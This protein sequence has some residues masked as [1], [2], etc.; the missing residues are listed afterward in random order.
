ME[1]TVEEQR[2]REAR[3][4]VPWRQWG[5]YLAERQWGTVREDYSDDGNAWDYFTHDQSRSRAYRWGEDGIAAV[6]DDHSQL[7]LAL[8]LW[9]GADPILKERLFGLTNSEGNHGE[10]VKELYFYVDSTPTHSW[11]RYRYRYPQR[12]FPY[13]DL[14]RTNA[15]RGYDDDEYELLDTGV[16]D[17]GRYFDVDVDYAKDGPQA[18]V[19]RVTV[20]NRGPEA[21]PVDVLPTLWFRNTWQW[22]AEH[23]KP[24]L[25]R[26]EAAGGVHVRATHHRLGERWLHVPAG[27]QLLFCEN[28]TNSERLWGT[29][30]AAAYVKDGIDRAVVHGEADAVGGERGTKVAVR[31]TAVVPAGGE[32]SFVVRLD[33]VAPSESA[34]VGADVVLA[35]RQ[36]EADEFYASITPP[37]LDADR[38][39]VLRTALAGMLWSKQHYFFDLDRWLQE[40][41]GHPLR[42]PRRQG[43]RNAG[44]AHMYNDDV[45]SMPDTWEYPWYAA[46]DLAFHTMA[47]AMV[48]PDFA[49]G[50]LELMLSS[51]YLHPTGQIPAY[52]WN[53]SDVNPPVHAWA[54]ALTY[55]LGRMLA[56]EPGE[57]AAGAD[58]VGFLEDAFSRLLVNFTWWVNRKD[59]SGNN[60]FEGGFLG[61][62]NVGVFDRSKPL[63]TGGHLEQADGTAWMAFYSQSMI[64]LAVLLSDHEPAYEGFIVKFVQHWMQIAM[65]M[66]PMGDH[67]D[68]MWDEEDGFFYDVLRLPDGTGRRLEVRSMVGLLPLCATAVV[69][70]H[71]VERFPRV[72]A[73]LRY[74]VERNADLLTGIPDPRVPGVDGRRLLA[75]VDETKLRR[76]LARM[77][78]EERFLSPHGIRSVSKWHEEH[79]YVFEADGQRYEVRYDPAD[80][81]SGAFGGN[82]NWRGPVWMPVNV[83]LIRALLQFYLYY[84]DDFTVE[85]PTGSGV[86]KTLYE[87]AHDLSDRL[88][89]TFTPGPDGRRPVFG[90]DTRF[91]DDPL[92]QDDLLFFEYFDGDTGAGL[93]ASHQTGWTGVVARLAQMFASTDAATVLHGPSRP[94]TVPYRRIADQSLAHRDDL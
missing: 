79:P 90:D 62:D 5:P 35:A 53:F 72:A 21:A 71:V 38:A 10:D 45:I 88:I 9:N 28:E 16:F 43:V 81:R 40:H 2:L 84:G 13:E 47:L 32:V 83:L 64:E 7:C 69:P 60:V 4:G 25:E 34:L 19:M 24:G 75:L 15:E 41:G 56:D 61:M 23:A 1:L 51:A 91:A 94:F 65:A 82:S 26:V 18:M 36:A 17:D 74:Y 78:D 55:G 31:F 58:D 67:P 92:W 93:G 8:A 66:D 77:L 22:D 39:H 54:V 30:N 44:W 33:D 14:V 49:K 87:V 6:C 68:E 80:S 29:P 86:H 3:E 73:E 89:T 27:A 37:S 52:E 20:H 12:T 76:I 59:P 63:P 11:M 85:C 70:G 48:D 46:W 42:A 50:Q 57:L